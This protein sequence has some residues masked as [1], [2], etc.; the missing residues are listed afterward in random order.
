MV[1]LPIETVGR[2]RHKDKNLKTQ[3]ARRN[4]AEDAER[5]RHTLPAKRFSARARPIIVKIE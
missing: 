3:R 5:E 4:F 1:F 2:E